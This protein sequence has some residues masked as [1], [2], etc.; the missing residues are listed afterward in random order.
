MKPIILIMIL[1]GVICVTFGGV[2]IAFAPM[3]SPYMS[4]DYPIPIGIIL[5]IVGEVLLRLSVIDKK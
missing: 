3:A 1:F 5:V 4:L 2:L